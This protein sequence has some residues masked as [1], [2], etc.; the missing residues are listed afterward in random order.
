[1]NELTASATFIA[2]VVVVV[3]LTLPSCAR[4]SR[5]GAI[6]TFIV[7]ITIQGTAV[8][9]FADGGGDPRP[10]RLLHLP[11]LEQRRGRVAQRRPRDRGGARPPGLLNMALLTVGMI[12]FIAGVVLAA[13]AALAARLRRRARP[14]RRRAWRRRRPA[15]GA[16]SSPGES[17]ARPPHPRRH[18][19]PGRRAAVRRRRRGEQGRD[20]VRD[21]VSQGC[22]A[23]DRPLAG[24]RHPEITCDKVS[25]GGAA[26]A[27]ARGRRRRRAAALPGLHRHACALGARA[28][29]RPAAGAE[30]RAGLHDGADP[31][32]RARAGAGR[33]RR[34][35]ERQAYLRALEGA[36][37]AQWPW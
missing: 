18:R 34:R 22:A 16:R 19:L 36:G 14:D 12:G 11:A 3:A 4:R 33:A 27:G 7:A 13:D 24:G 31:P 23:F 26:R 10:A 30:D 32:R 37:P 6:C 28:V 29:R 9:L 5:V 2:G 17:A 35:A 15:S 20:R 25:Q 8:V 21:T 1:M